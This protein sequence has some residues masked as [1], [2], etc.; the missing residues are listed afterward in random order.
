M[1]SA[2]ICCCLQFSPRR[3]CCKAL[4]GNGISRRRTSSF[5]VRQFSWPEASGVPA[6]RSASDQPGEAV[7]GARTWLGRLEFFKPETAPKA[8][9]P[10]DHRSFRPR[11]GVRASQAIFIRAGAADP[12]ETEP[13]K[14]LREYMAAQGSDLVR[15]D[16]TLQA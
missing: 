12:P 6:Q 15:H 14:G 10:I 13:G 9:I 5:C 2:M 11:L 7:Q 8:T 3:D 16:A 4:T 1:L